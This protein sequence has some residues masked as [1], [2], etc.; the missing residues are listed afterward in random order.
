VVDIDVSFL[1]GGSRKSLAAW[2]PAVRGS[3]TRVAR[4][5]ARVF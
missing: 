2:L 3:R 5:I 4:E 1:I